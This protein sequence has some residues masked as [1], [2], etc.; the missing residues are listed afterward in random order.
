MSY[1]HMAA[2]FESLSL[3]YSDVSEEW[4]LD[5]ANHTIL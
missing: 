3:A 2:Q 5:I 1:L 4:A